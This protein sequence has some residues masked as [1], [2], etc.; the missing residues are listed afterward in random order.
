MKK[1][2]LI[3]KI[4]EALKELNLPMDKGI[5]LGEDAFLN[6]LLDDSEKI[7]GFCI[8]VY[9]DE[10]L[11][12]GNEY[13]YPLDQLAKSDLEHIYSFILPK[14]NSYLVLNIDKI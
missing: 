9:D 1:L 8:S 5:V 4:E 10:P 13:V 2:V 6:G 7:Y 14:L 11:A 3:H 12:I